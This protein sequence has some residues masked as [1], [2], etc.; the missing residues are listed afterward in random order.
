M[1]E[2]K[3]CIRR[4]ARTIFADILNAYR[5]S[6]HIPLLRHQ[7]QHASRLRRGYASEAIL[8]DDAPT[9]SPTLDVGVRNPYV[10]RPSHPAKEDEPFSLSNLGREVRWLK[11]PLKLGDH[12]VKLLRQNDAQK[13]LEIVRLASKNAECTVSWNYMIDYHMSKGDVKGAVK[14]YNEV[15]PCSV[16]GKVSALLKSKLP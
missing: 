12:I 10:P 4:F 14:L 8:F 9:P 15:R 6:S 16:F 5:S 13:A 2:C 7:A 1:F 11:D 3:T